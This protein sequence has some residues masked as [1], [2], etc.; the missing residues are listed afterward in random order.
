MPQEL[1]DSIFII[2]DSLAPHPGALIHDSFFGGPDIC[3]ELHDY[4]GVIFSHGSVSWVHCLLA[5][6]SWNFVYSPSLS[7]TCLS[8]R[9]DHPLIAS[10]R[11][12]CSSLR[13]R[14]LS[15]SIF[16]CGAALDPSPAMSFLAFLLRSFFGAICLQRH[17]HKKLV[18]M[19]YVTIILVI[20][21]KQEVNQLC[22]VFANC[23][24]YRATNTTN[25]NLMRI[26]LKEIN[27]H[28]QFRCN[29]PIIV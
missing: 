7:W 9:K 12:W 14:C 2:G 4:L 29:V 27:I 20:L 24:C 6:S 26:I 11:H 28:Q 5:T 18:C 17:I 22:V 25:H 15:N 21:R 13:K 3:I 10:K 23:M 1:V 19:K 16:A 8:L